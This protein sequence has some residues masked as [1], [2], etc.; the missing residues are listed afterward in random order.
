M[1]AEP[2]LNEIAEVF[3]KHK[4][5]AVMI[6]NA[7]AAMRGAPVT[8]LDI[9]F[10]IRDAAPVISK[11]SKVAASLGASL[12]QPFLPTSSMRRLSN[13]SRG[14]QLDFVVQA[15]GI[16]SFASLRSRATAAA[17]GKHSLLIASLDDIIRSKRSAGRPQDLA[18]LPILEVLQQETQGDDD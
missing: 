5:E 16:D 17:F 2:L 7:A 18:V 14:L 13:V 15:H 4:L 8:T 11:L 12:E 6:G 10:M 9:D 1:N 3:H